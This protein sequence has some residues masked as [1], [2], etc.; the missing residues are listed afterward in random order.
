MVPSS[1]MLFFNKCAD[2]TCCL[3]VSVEAPIMAE[4]T[5]ATATTGG[6]MA[7][8]MKIM[9]TMGKTTMEA[10]RI[11]AKEMTAMVL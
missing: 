9:E 6:T 8:I 3:N 2:L 10:H 11:V 7:K 1:V 4:V 5:M